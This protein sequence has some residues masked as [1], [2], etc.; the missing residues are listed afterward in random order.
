MAATRGV[1]LH[2]R[3]VSPSPNWH[4][5]IYGCP[6]DISQKVEVARE[7]ESNS[8]PILFRTHFPLSIFFLF[9][10]CALRRLLPPLPRSHDAC[11]WKEGKEGRKE[12]THTQP[13]SLPSSLS[14][15]SFKFEMSRLLSHHG[16]K[17]KT[18]KKGTTTTATTFVDS[19]SLWYGGRKSS[20]IGTFSK[21]CVLIAGIC[22][23]GQEG[24]GGKTPQ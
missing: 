8:A 19:T 13:L 11:R 24:E 10:S 14:S 7:T 22:S 16:W 3:R 5:F 17:N 12:P 15:F 6:H 23:V 4:N 1:L 2:S 18:A 21:T 9:H 20:T